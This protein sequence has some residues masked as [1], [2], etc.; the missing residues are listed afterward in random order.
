MTNIFPSSSYSLIALKLSMTTPTKR[1]I[2]NW[3]PITIN[4]RKKAITYTFAFSFGC[5]PTPRLS[6]PLYITPIHPSVVVI[7]KRV[8]IAAKV[9]SKF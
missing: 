9:L 3:L 8:F 5:K 7:W 1:L 4:A 2:M 6:M